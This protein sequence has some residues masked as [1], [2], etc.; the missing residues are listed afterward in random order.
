MLT[1]I[2]EELMDSPLYYVIDKLANVIHCSVPS[3]LQ[4]RSAIISLGYKVSSTHANS[5]GVKTNAPNSGRKKAALSLFFES[6]KRLS[7]IRIPYYLFLLCLGN[8]MLCSVN[9]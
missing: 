3:M 2:S 5:N 7:C 9:I 1:V 6:G 4:F 8:A